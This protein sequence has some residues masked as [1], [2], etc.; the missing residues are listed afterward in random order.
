MGFQKNRIKLEDIARKLNISIATVSRAL[1]KNPRVKLS[2]QEKVFVCRG[3]DQYAR[4]HNYRILISSSRNS[5]DF[6]SENLASFERGLVDGIIVSPTHQTSNFEH[7]QNM[8]KRGMP[9]VLFDNIIEDLSGADQVLIQDQKAAQAAVEFLIKK[10]RKKIV[11]V[12][13]VK[14]KKVFSDRFKGYQA[15]LQKHN[16]PF[17]EE[18]VLHCRSFNRE[19]EASDIKRFFAN[20][21][22]TF[23]GVFANTDNHGLI[24]MKTLLHM[25]YQI[26]EQISIVGFGDL[27]VADMYVPSMSCVA[28]PSFEMGQKA[29]KLLIDQLKAN[30]DGIHERKIITL[31]TK[32]VLRDST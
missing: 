1:D 32:L 29:A 21:K 7:F 5:F 9:I 16:I 14:E 17:R 13:G 10:G 15:A 24:A 31:D 26:P 19:E 4:K 27:G 25:K 23:D 18:L 30:T 3:I 28:Q 12:G 8:I 11:F 20:C 2:T 6:E 22:T